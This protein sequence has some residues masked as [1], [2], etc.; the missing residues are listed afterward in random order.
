MRHYD[1]DA[2]LSRCDE[3]LISSV[4][5]VSSKEALR[6]PPS[7]S[8]LTA[9][10]RGNAKIH[11]PVVRRTKPPTGR[12][13]CQEFRPHALVDENCVHIRSVD[14]PA[15]APPLGVGHDRVREI[16]GPHLPD[17]RRVKGKEAATGGYD[18]D[19]AVFGAN[20]RG[21]R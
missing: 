14:S 6:S 12:H 5:V 19:P 3:T 20:R 2:V 1:W 16:E 13:L 4:C 15:H 7:R 11:T 8:S 18:S 10:K 17:A 21:E 9:V